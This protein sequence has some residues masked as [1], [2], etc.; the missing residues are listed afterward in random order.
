MQLPI[1]L[2]AM[3]KDA[4]GK[5]TKM[6]SLLDTYQMYSSISVYAGPPAV[7]IVGIKEKQSPEL[8][9]QTCMFWIAERS[10]SSLL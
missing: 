5:N 6:K 8:R 4:Q 3:A 10:L 9:F 1:L 2:L 7:K